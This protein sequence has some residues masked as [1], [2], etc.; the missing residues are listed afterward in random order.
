MT[1]RQILAAATL[2]LAAC[3]DGFQ[4]ENPD[5]QS[6]FTV[7]GTITGYAGSGLVLIEGTAQITIPAGATTFVFVTTYHAGDHYEIAVKT[8]PTGPLQDCAAPN[9]SGS[10]SGNVSV[11]IVCTT[12]TYP[13]TP[14]IEGVLRDGLVLQNNGTDDLAI[15]APQGGGP[16]TASFAT[17]IASGAT[18][19][20]SVKTNPPGQTCAVSGGT[21]TV[22]N[23]EITSIMVNCANNQY[24]I[25]GTVAG[26]AGS[27]L[28]LKNQGGNDLAINA[29]GTFAFTTTH[30]FGDAYEITVDANP[31]SPW[32]TCTVTQGS[33]AV[34]AGDVND[35]AIT[36][37]TNRYDVA[38]TVMGLAGTGLVLQN[39]GGDDLAVSAPGT[40]TFTTQ[41]E[42][43]ASFLVAVATGPTSPWQT[44][45]VGGGSG[46]I[47]NTGVNVI[48]SCSTNQYNVVGTVTGLAGNGLEL[49]N[50]SETIPVPAD[51]PF[52]FPT[53]V[54]SGG[55][56]DVTVTTQPTSLSQ[57]C[58]V[59]GGSGTIT[60]ANT[61]VQVSC[62]TNSYHVGGTVVGLAGTGLTLLN[63][64]GDSIPVTGS[65]FTFPTALLS[66]ASFAVTVGNNPSNLWQT[67]VVANDTGMVTSADITS[68]VVTCT[69][70]LYVVNI[71]V[72]GLAG[73]GLVVQ[74][75]GG[76][77]LPILADGTIAFT[78]PVPSGG[79]FAVTV[80]TQPTNLSQTC[81]VT[82]GSGTISNDN[83]TAQ[84]TCSTNSYHVGGTVTGL[85][86][87]GLVLNN[88]AGDP[89]PVSADGSF[90]FPTTLLSGQAY[91]V[92][93]GSDPTLPWQTCTVTNDAGT[94]TSADITSV[95][96]NCTT[97][98]YV[99][100]V[101]VTGLLG[102]GLV[103]QN[104]GG[105]D[106]AIT[107][108]GTTAFAAAVSSGANF[109]V[110]V[111]SAPATPTQTCSITDGSGTIAGGNVT[112]TVSCVTNTYSVGGS[113]SGLLPGDSLTV[114]NNGGDDITLT[115]DGPFTFATEVASGATYVVV[116]ATSS[117]LFCGVTN[118]SGT[119][120]GAAITN[121]VVACGH[122]GAAT[123]NAT[124]AAQTFT[125]PVAVT[126]ITI[127]AFGAAG[128]S[129][130][131]GV[132]GGLGGE[133]TGTL[134][135]TP[136]QVLTVMVGGW[137]SSTA[138]N[139]GGA[140]GSTPCANAMAGTGG[141]AS[142]V[143]TGAAGL[144][145][146]VIV[147]GGG[148]GAAGNR[149]GACGRGTGGGGGG[150]FFGGGG[151]AAW[152]SASVVV[153]TGGT[154][155]AGGTGGTS[156]FA[157]APGNNGSAGD[158]GVGGAGG[159]EVSSAQGGSATGAVGATGGGTTGS[160]G[161]YAGSFTG[162][163]G[164]GGSGYIGGV[165][166]GSMSSGI[167]AGAGGE[168]KVV[169]SW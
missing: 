134:A 99:V 4:G 103:L 79:S 88:N 86:G 49:H 162:Q 85:T 64:A 70:N 20:L 16:V 147:A 97:N 93:V 87:T 135:V 95:A 21:G 38:V 166:G 106:L 150:G 78:T 51:G 94:V 80:A 13:I 131:L 2:L 156:T 117:G 44:C 161:T 96:V 155:L 68:V 112:V 5:A 53:S 73:T 111:L 104:N 129:N 33:G 159:A 11:A 163:S 7:S 63:N 102:S 109:D 151:G 17:Q 114:T 41:V 69:T 61:A 160:N 47:T 153:P 154:Q 123:F 113:A 14:T 167:D 10:V 56:F 144:A 121:V 74:N 55:A 127:D 165:T 3:G 118:G 108:D 12:R 43:G 130:A 169:I 126:Q 142:D 152:P 149:I 128:G 34:G 139:G 54:A 66:G 140:A 46:T 82:D 30:V 62:S 120:A 8:Q 124:G 137:G 45:A 143:R 24:A 107:G 168:G 57:T 145:D 59:T 22:V 25:G 37:A 115:A 81:T 91:A 101:S 29:N 32:Q 50:G 39:N 26:L 36:C 141:G 105:D 89:I 132:L 60:N 76:D 84:I 31:I 100:N 158:V 146:R 90:T 65:S 52:T 164:A 40:S 125:V 72:T 35:I 19:A 119:I 110:T 28:T 75:N 157:S 83:V 18:Y 27:G 9:G 98:S 116:A 67:C 71:G 48:V 23:G 42:S 92:T 133:A 15:P 136:G 1:P 6:S 148:G 77:D 122:S 138:F 58:T